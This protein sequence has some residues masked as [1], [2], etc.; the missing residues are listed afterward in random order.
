MGQLN[1]CVTTVSVTFNNRKELERT[2]QS[3]TKVSVQPVEIIIIDGGS[4]DGSVD[5]IKSYISDLPQLVYI[6]EDDNGIFDAMNKGRRLVKTK[7]IHYLPAGDYLYGE[8]Y[9]GIVRPS[10]IP[11]GFVDELGME[12]GEDKVKLFGTGYNH[13]GMI[14]PADH[15]EYDTSLWVAA[16]YKMSLEVF[17]RGLSSELFVRNGGVKYQLGGLSTQRSLLVA[18]QLVVGVFKVRPLLAIPVACILLIKSVV[19]RAL[20]RWILRRR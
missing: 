4:T 13:Q 14:V 15:V 3:L 19:P 2:L 18:Y 10:L 7:L 5:L 8:P 17:P 16:D 20:R 12:C 1:P 11:V 6:S 9:K